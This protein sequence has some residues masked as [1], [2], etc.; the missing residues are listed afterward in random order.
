M[1][2]F[3]GKNVVATKF[4]TVNGGQCGQIVPLAK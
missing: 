4:G 3:S 1:R 2:T